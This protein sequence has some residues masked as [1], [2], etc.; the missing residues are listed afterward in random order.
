MIEIIDEVIDLLR[1]DM[2]RLVGILVIPIIVIG[3]ALATY[4]AG[5]FFGSMRSHM[6]LISIIKE[7]KACSSIGV[8]FITAFLSGDNLAA[9][10]LINFNPLVLIAWYLQILLIELIAIFIFVSIFHP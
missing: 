4:Y 2:G 1:E 7:S 5:V 10:E 9:C 3:I 6:D 8:Y